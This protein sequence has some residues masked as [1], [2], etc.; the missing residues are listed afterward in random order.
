MR[1]GRTK[2]EESIQAVCKG[3]SKAYQ[4]LL[5]EN[6]IFATLAD[7]SLDGKA[8]YIWNVVCLDVK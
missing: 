1:R 8:K 2:F 6:G 7:G 5:R 4:L 3:I